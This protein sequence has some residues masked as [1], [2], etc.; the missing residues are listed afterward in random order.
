MPGMSTEILLVRHGQSV[1]NT[2]DLF[3]GHDDTPL[4]PLGM[5]QARALGRRL[6]KTQIDAVIASDLS[7]A[8]D[9]ARL[10]THGRGLALALDPRL[11]EMHYGEWEALPGKALGEKHPELMRAFFRGEAAAPGGETVAELRARTAPALLEI[12]EAHRGR[13]V[14]V[15]S[16]GNAMMAMV[17]ELLALPLSATWA[18]TFENTSLTRLHV[19]KSNR[20]TVRSLND[21]AHIEGLAESHA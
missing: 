13:T 5:A 7:R 16:H 1:G 4:T 6:A 3:C 14:M 19:S 18:F 10:A 11:R 15:V 2:L 8:A 17:A 21:A 12:A 20:L 9:T